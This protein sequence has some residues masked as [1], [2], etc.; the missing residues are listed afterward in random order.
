MASYFFCQLSIKVSGSYLKT[1]QSKISFLSKIYVRL[2]SVFKSFTHRACLW[3]YVCKQVQQLPRVRI[4]NQASET[5]LVAHVPINLGLCCV[6]HTP[7]SDVVS[8]ARCA[9][10]WRHAATST[11]VAAMIGS[12]IGDPPQIPPLPQSGVSNTK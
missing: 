9:Q 3:T 5:C 8:S 12:H 1:N 7:A 4:R 11:T 10:M 2:M 6:C